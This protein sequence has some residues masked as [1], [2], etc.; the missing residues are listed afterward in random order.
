MTDVLNLEAIE[1]KAFSAHLQA[2]YWEIFIGCVF[3]ALGLYSAADSGIWMDL[4][5]GLTIGAAIL[6]VTLIRTRLVQPRLGTAVFGPKRKARLSRV[7][8]VIAA[9]AV[10]G[11]AIFYLTVREAYGFEW[12]VWT[13][14][15][16][17]GLASGVIIFLFAAVVARLMD[18]RLFYVV[19]LVCGAGFG[20][21]AVTGEPWILVGAGA[22]VVFIG[23]FQLFRF[24]RT[25][26]LPQESVPRDSV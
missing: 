13:H 21:K 8:A 11:V 24:L 2:G 1:K 10:F 16:A 25:Y 12:V 19:G 6:V 26:P 7:T 15:R 18:H 17:L 20:G 4:L 22:L 9:L 14:G 23:A 3:L 5:Y